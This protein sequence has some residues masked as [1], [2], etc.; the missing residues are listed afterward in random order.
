MTLK[1]VTMAD[2]RAEPAAG[3]DDDIPDRLLTPR[4]VAAMLGISDKTLERWRGTGE[5]PLFVRLSGKCVRYR[6]E[7]VEEFVTTRI[8]TSTAA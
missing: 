4:E 6:R 3:S 5:G 2:R 1:K 8:A 7:D